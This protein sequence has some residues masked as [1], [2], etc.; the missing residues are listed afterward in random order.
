MKYRL[1]Y[2]SSLCGFILSFLMWISGGVRQNRQ[3]IW[4]ALAILHIAIAAYCFMDINYNILLLLF[5]FTMFYFD[6]S[7]LIINRI[8]KRQIKSWAIKYDITWEIEHKANAIYFASI[9]L[10]FFSFYFVK[11]PIKD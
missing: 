2:A 7:S 11:N 8:L 9:L 4:L 10:V 6:T 5:D 3:E 1:L